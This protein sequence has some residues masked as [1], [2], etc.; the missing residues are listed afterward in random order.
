MKIYSFFDYLYLAFYSKSFY[1]EIGK[2]HKGLCLGYLLFILCIFLIPEISQI[3]SEVSDYLSV[4]A[5][6]YVKQTPVITISKGHASIKEPVPYYIN[7]PVKKTPFAV[8]DTSGQITSLDKTTAYVLLT[9]TKLIVKYQSFN[10]WTRDLKGI[11]SQIID[12]K[13]LQQW[14]KDFD[15]L[16]PFVLFPFVLLFSFLFHIIQVLPAAGF[17]RLF[18]KKIK[19]DIDFR[20]LVRLAIVSFTPA[21]ILQTVHTLLDIPFP[22][23]TP[24]AFI[25][26]LGYLYYAVVLNSMPSGPIP[27]KKTS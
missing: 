16:F 9:D 6:K 25:I 24:I 2:K 10:T 23:R 27:D 12:Q 17:G 3:H 20:S 26:S 13:V 11:E 14:I 7:D 21:I 18:A 22:Y 4:E 1:Q 19:A 15:T 5:A 8:I